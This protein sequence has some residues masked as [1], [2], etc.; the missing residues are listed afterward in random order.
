MQRSSSRPGQRRGLTTVRSIERKWSSRRSTTPRS[1][2]GPPL[3]L[4][5]R[6]SA[7]HT[8]ARTPAAPHIVAAFRRCRPDGRFGKRGAHPFAV[9]GSTR[10]LS[11]CCRRKDE[12]TRG[13]SCAPVSSWLLVEN[14][15]SLVRR[16]VL[17][18]RPA[19]IDCRLRR[20]VQSA[21]ASTSHA[22]GSADRPLSR[23]FSHAGRIPPF[24][25]LVVGV[26]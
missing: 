17:G 8:C 18:Q 15:G 6:A 1:A 2:P 3:T 25:P 21:P 11:R 19:P 26:S 13:A 12:D 16:M 14:A 9:N 7:A 4:S 10:R 20:T 5:R 22:P 24:L 23:P